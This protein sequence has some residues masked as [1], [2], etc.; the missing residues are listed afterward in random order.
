MAD[1]AFCRIAAGESD[2]HL[3]HADERTVAF[4]DAHP[5][6][7]GHALVAPTGHHEHLLTADAS[8]AADV[9]RTVRAVAR[10]LN[11]V[12]DPDGVSLF[13]TTATLVGTVTHAHVHLLPRYADDDVR[14]SLAREPLDEDAAAR[15]TAA[16][17]EVV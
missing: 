14:L 8:L 10:G 5:A 9:F 3:L 6:V 17:R 12:L 2:A 16:V 11:E 7:R 13:Y 1:C 4:L 15:L